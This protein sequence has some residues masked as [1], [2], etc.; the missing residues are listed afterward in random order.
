MKRPDLTII[1][2]AYCEERRIGRSLDSLAAFIT[3]DSFMKRLSIEVLVVAADA[4]DNTHAIVLSKKD[5]F[6]KFALLKPG[7][8]IGKGR[9]VQYGM[10]RASG[11][12]IL[13]MDADLATPLQHIE[14]FYKLCTAGADVVIGTRDLL[15][16]RPNRLRNIFAYLGN[17]LYRVVGGLSVADTQCGFKMFA[18]VASHL[19]FSRLTIMGWGFDLEILAI[20]QANGLTIKS[21]PLADWQHQPFSTYNDNAF[22]IALRTIRDFAIITVNRIKGRYTA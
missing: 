2:P 20:A 12:Y 10:L 17:Q 6:K 5:M 21:I 19:C 8:R 9:D 1:I 3:T 22:Q 18:A 13:F 15:H 11:T 4:P 14:A 16:Y 7:P